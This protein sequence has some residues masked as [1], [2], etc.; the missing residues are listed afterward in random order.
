[1]T[2][3]NAG[4][5]KDTLRV[6]TAR[7]ATVIAAARSVDKARAACA[8]LGGDTV[9][10]AC[11]LSEPASVRAAVQ[12]VRGLGRSLDGIIANAG[13]MALPDRTVKYGLEL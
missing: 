3:C 7:G 2:G 9:P 6:L 5:G 12:T 1:M 13:I 11:E 4:L 10:L 8:E